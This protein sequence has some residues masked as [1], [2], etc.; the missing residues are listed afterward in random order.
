MVSQT[1]D[2]TYERAR[3]YACHSNPLRMMGENE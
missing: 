2:D 3:G 1:N